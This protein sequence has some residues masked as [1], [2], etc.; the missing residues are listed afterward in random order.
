MKAWI[1][2]TLLMVAGA[3]LITD[4]RTLAGVALIAW[5]GYFFRNVSIKVKSWVE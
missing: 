3:C 5:G 1:F 2:G 4:W